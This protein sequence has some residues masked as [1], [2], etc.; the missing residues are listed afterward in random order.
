MPEVEQEKIKNGEMIELTPT[1]SDNNALQNPD[2]SSSNLVTSHVN[3]SFLL[4]LG[5]KTPSPKSNIGG[6][7]NYTTPISKVK[8]FS[9]TERGMSMLKPVFKFDDIS[10][11]ITPLKEFKQ[12]SSRIRKNKYL[13]NKS[14]DQIPRSGNIA[15]NLEDSP[16]SISGLFK[17]KASGKSARLSRQGRDADVEDLM[18][19]SW[20]YNN[21]SFY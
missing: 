8:T 11:S 21:T 3:S 2:L 6:L 5:D 16:S 4:Q 18:D 7:T 14:V 1:A 19:M 20:R 13:Q 12:G 15:A 10:T 9:D 17:S